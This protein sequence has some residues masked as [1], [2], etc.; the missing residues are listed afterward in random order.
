MSCEQR[1]I[2]D[3]IGRSLSSNWLVSDVRYHPIT[4][5]LKH[6][7]NDPYL[8]NACCL[9]PYPLWVL[10]VWWKWACGAALDGEIGFECDPGFVFTLQSPNLVWILNTVFRR[11]LRRN[12]WPQTCGPISINIRLSTQNNLRYIL[13][14]CIRYF[15]I[16]YQASLGP[17][18][19]KFCPRDVAKKVAA[20]KVWRN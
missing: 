19:T 3:V 7:A 15:K 16:L 1:S 6:H 2:N 5:R 12:R 14:G 13:Y 11:C 17:V 9:V 4:R 18:C 20:I 10:S 8:R